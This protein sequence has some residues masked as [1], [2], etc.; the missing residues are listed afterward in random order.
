M[1][2]SKYQIYT[3]HVHAFLKCALFATFMEPLAVYATL[4]WLA[5]FALLAKCSHLQNT[6]RQFLKTSISKL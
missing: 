6:K 2:S 3:L 1:N 4:H 5:Y